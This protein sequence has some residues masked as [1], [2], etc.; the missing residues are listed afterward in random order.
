MYKSRFFLLKILA[1]ATLIA[2]TIIFHPTHQSNLLTGLLQSV[3]ALVSCS[4]F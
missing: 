3:S 1:A 4:L 2:A